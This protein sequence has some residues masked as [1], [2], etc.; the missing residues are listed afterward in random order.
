MLTD[1]QKAIVDDEDFPVLNRFSWHFW[2]N[3]WKVFPHTAYKTPSE[4]SVTHNIPITTFLTVNKNGQHCI[5]KDGNYLN[6][7]KENLKLVNIHTKK[8]NN[9]KINQYKGEKVSSEYKGVSLLRSGKWRAYTTKSCIIDSKLIKKQIHLG[10]FNTE[11]EAASAYNKKVK[12]IFGEFAYQN[13][14]D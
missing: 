7:Q 8:Q 4:N 11:K 5:A 14:I 12:I 13:K 1:G 3:K 6:C 10:T 2:N 9:R